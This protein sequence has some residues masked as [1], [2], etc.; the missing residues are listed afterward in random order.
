MVGGGCRTEAGDALDPLAPESPIMSLNVRGYANHVLT[1]R[2]RPRRPG[3]PPQR[4]W[5]SASVLTL[6]CPLH[7]DSALVEGRLVGA[8]AVQLG[9]SLRLAAYV[10][11]REAVKARRVRGGGVR[12]VEGQAAPL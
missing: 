2:P 1:E 5:F 3:R 6:H 4:C 9:A 11:H 7:C 8:S 12:T 10:F